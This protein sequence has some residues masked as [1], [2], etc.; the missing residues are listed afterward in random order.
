VLLLLASF[1]FYGMPAGLAQQLVGRS[2]TGSLGPKYFECPA[3]EVN[4][5]APSNLMYTSA[6]QQK[7]RCRASNLK[8]P[9]QAKPHFGSIDGRA[10]PDQTNPLMSDL[11]VSEGLGSGVY[12][13]SVGGIAFDQVAKPQGRL[14]VDS[15]E[16]EYDRSQ[17]DGSRL[18]VVLNGRGCP[19]RGLPDWQL[20]PIA[21]YADTSYFGVVT[22]FGEPAGGQPRPTN[23]EYVVSYHPAFEGTLL[24]LR[25]FQGDIMLLDPNTTGELP[26]FLGRYR[27]GP[28][29]R[30]PNRQAWQQ[31]SAALNQILARGDRFASYLICDAAST[32][33]F[34][35]QG[36]RRTRQFHVEGIVYFGFW[37]RGAEKT[38]EFSAPGRKIVYRSFEPVHLDALSRTVSSQTA[39]L[40]RVNPAVYRS[41]YNTMAYAAFFRYCKQHDP[42]MWE[43]FLESLAAIPGT[44]FAAPT[45]TLV[46]A[47]PGQTRRTTR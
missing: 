37:K 36:S 31:A 44:D 4:G 33:T 10:G 21:C 35:M 29:E 8:P 6:Y 39:L 38:E 47:A 27:L 24:G 12:L 30:P 46:Y 16:L 32:P 23:V 41:M 3:P 20:L 2:Q 26:Q 22:L 45:P 40:T 28:G 1:A 5:L 15:L 19:A 9:G 17:P 13:S 18:T 7:A 25:L 34:G 11:S 14:A 42:K 43:T